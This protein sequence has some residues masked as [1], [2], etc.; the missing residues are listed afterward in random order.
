MKMM[1]E[2]WVLIIAVVCSPGFLIFEQASRK[3]TGNR[4]ISRRLYGSLNILTTR[5]M[6]IRSISGKQS[7]RATNDTISFP[8]I[9]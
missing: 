8:T 1:N 6:R 2:L 4:A 7:V 3:F 9:S 5:R